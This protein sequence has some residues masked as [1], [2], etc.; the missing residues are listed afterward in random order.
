LFEHTVSLL[1]L[2]L[3]DQAEVIKTAGMT[4]KDLVALNTS[5]SE[6]MWKKALEAS[7][8]AEKAGINLSWYSLLRSPK[9][10]QQKYSYGY[11]LQFYI[12]RDLM[13][14]GVRKQNQE[15]LNNLDK[16]YFSGNW[17][18]VGKL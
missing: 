3:D 2:G 6:N 11:W 9:S 18:L 17:K 10:L 14:L 8:V 15:F 12:Y 7:T 5:V 1:K 13:E 4:Y 16:A